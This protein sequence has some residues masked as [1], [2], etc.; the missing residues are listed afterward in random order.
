MSA[1]TPFD[2]K[3][4]KVVRR[5]AELRDALADPARAGG[6]FA[7]LSKEYSDLT[8]L[9]ETI[10]ALMK[11]RREQTD[12]EALSREG[13]ADMRSLAEAEMRVLEK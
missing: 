4:E 2:V 6:D 12:L 10:D 5:H 13:E 9:A 7:K 3:L 8:P 1:A 11:T